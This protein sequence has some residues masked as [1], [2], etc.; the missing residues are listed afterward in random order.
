MSVSGLNCEAVLLSYLTVCGRVHLGKSGPSESRER[1][2][3]AALG[4]C[5]CLCP[6]HGQHLDRVEHPRLVPLG[7]LIRGS[8]R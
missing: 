4:W 7:L 8:G 2:A 6:S 3:P 5:V 1:G